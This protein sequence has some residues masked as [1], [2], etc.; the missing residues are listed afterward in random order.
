MCTYKLQTTNHKLRTKLPIELFVIIDIAAFLDLLFLVRRADAP[1]KL[2]G[3]V[4]K[5]SA[6][7]SDNP[8]FDAAEKSAHHGHGQPRAGIIHEAGESGVAAGLA[9]TRH[10]LFG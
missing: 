8:V 10:D 2:V 9:S 4:L 1:V 3:D 5:S 7:Q 6:D